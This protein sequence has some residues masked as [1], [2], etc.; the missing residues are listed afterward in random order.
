MSLLTEYFSAFRHF[1]RNARLYLINNALSY[2]TVG[3]IL[4]LYNLYLVALGYRADFIG[5]VLF[6]GTLGAGLAI[7][8]AGLCIDRF[9]GKAILIWS[10]VLIGLTGAGQ[11]LLRQ[12]VPLLISAF[13][14]GIGAAFML[15]VN[16]PFLTVNSAPAERSLLFSLNIVVSLIT[17]VLGELLGGILPVWLRAWPWAMAPLPY[18]LNGLLVSQPLARSYQLALLIAGL[19][20][21]PSFIPLF[22]MSDDRPHQAAEPAHGHDQSVPAEGVEVQGVEVLTEGSVGHTAESLQVHMGVGEV[23]TGVMTI[24]KRIALWRSTDI[25]VVVGSALFTMILVQILIGMGAGLFIPYFNIY[26]VQ[27]LGASSALFGLIDGCANALNALLTLLAPLLVLRIGRINTLV[28]TRLLSLPLLLIIGLT[29]W[30][31]L[32]AALY[33][34]RQGLMDMSNGIL[35]VFSMEVVAERHRGMANSS[36]QAAFQAANGVATPIGGLIIARLGYTPVFILAAILYLAALALMWKR[37]S[38]QEI[39]IN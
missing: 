5:L 1:Q 13:L 17:T 38:R 2:V 21:A 31:P 7:F 12:P 14:A 28:F 20:A 3:I 23:H 8:P 6:M 10:S 30:L 27:H 36:Y 34:L 4:V 19:I 18:G 15:V 24:R 22:M 29:S 35:Q 37:F 16:A 26:F 39:G 9:G 33:P 32:A 25:R 11:M